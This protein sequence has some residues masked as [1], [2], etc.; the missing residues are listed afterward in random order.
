MPLVPTINI[1]STA[2]GEWISNVQII[3]TVTAQLSEAVLKV[4]EGTNVWV[5]ASMTGQ[6]RRGS[7]GGTDSRD[8][9]DQASIESF[10]ASDP[11]PWTAGR[12]DR[13]TELKGRPRRAKRKAA[14][15]SDAAA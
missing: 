4:L 11:P 3:R 15:P 10:P 9:V 14:A 12:E 13:P 2:I 5:R 8:I 7:N 1:A 6:G